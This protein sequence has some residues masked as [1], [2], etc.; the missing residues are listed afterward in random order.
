M[1]FS[2][3]KD[4]LDVR[5][6]GFSP[7]SDLSSSLK[8]LFRISQPVSRMPFDKP[9]YESLSPAPSSKGRKMFFRTENSKAKR[10]NSSGFRLNNLSSMKEQCYKSSFIC[11]LVKT[12]LNLSSFGGGGG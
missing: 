9:W 12:F 10:R 5:T 2:S 4:G 8:C 1:S 6:D 7:G 3:V 11:S